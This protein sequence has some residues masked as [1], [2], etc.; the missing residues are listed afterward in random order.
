MMIGAKDLGWTTKLEL[1]EGAKATAIPKDVTM[2]NP[3]GS[4]TAHYTLLPDGLLVERRLLIAH[5]IYQPQDVK[6]L[7]AVIYAALD[8]ARAPFTVTRAVGE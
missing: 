4:Y 1:P 7:E 3:A 6:S 5:S 8:D 2:V